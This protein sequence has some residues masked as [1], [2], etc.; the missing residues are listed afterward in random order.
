[1]PS[2]ARADL[3]RLL[4]ARKLDGT[5]Q[6]PGRP[7][8]RDTAPTS[9]SDV[10]ARLDGGLPRGQTSEIVGARS[11]GRT[12]LLYRVLAA[13]SSRGE[14]VSLIDPLDRFDPASAA[15]AGV[16]LSRILWVRGTAL[17]PGLLA[18]GL[19][20]MPRWR[21]ADG[22]SSGSREFLRDPAALRLN[23]PCLADRG[24]S[25]GLLAHVL[26]RAVKATGLVLAAGGFG[27]VALD[28]ADVP[29]RT[30]MRLPFT[31]W[32]RLQRALDGS[33][34]VL[35][36]VATDPV[37]R[38]AGGVSLRVAGTPCWQ[39]R[40]DRARVFGGIERDVRIASAEACQ[41]SNI[42]IKH[43]ALS[44]ENASHECS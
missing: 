3:E 15:A 4:R 14:A 44:I 21:S 27:L 28:L 23:P 35:A 13:A 37:A 12:G 19:V 11:S 32:F 22:G 25:H 2:V 41:A 10:D 38:S 20:Q 29:R 40:S 18:Q 17:S 43:C 30:V 24:D 8:W 1:M 16:E 26:D 6:D 5:V 7:I 39:G 42:D 33:D 36:I 34:T 9:D 31:T